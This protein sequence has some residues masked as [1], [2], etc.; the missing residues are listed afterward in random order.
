[1]KDIAKQIV[2]KIVA[3]ITAKT[4]KRVRKELCDKWE[5]IINK[6]LYENT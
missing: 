3:T 6:E 1:M 2:Q 5:E 4:T